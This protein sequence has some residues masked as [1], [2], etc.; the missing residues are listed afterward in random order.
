LVVLALAGGGL[1][2]CGD[3]R[4]VVPSVFRIA[5]PA[6]FHPYT[7]P[8]YGFTLQVPKNWTDL[9]RQARAPVVM[10][11]AS[12]T[13]VMAISQYAR[14]LPAPSDSLSLEQAQKSLLAAIRARQPGFRLLGAQRVSVGGLPAVRLDAIERIDGRSRRVRSLHVFQA[15]RELVLE[16]YAPESAFSRVDRQVFLR[17]SRSL[18]LGRS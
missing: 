3:S 15:T 13:A 1:G 12:G 18:R 8:R 17:A 5:G 10:V 7:S 6:G 14:S 2:A 11:V 4:T 9:G 16:E